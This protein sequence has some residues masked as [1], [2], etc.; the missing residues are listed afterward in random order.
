MER[1]VQ[2]S[3]QSLMAHLPIAAFVARAPDGAIVWFNA[4]AAELWGRQP[5]IGDPDERCCRPCAADGSFPAHGATPVAEVLKSGMPI[6]GK[7]MVIERPDGSRATVC[8][9]VDP[10]RDEEGTIVGV[11]NFFSDT[12]ERKA[13]ELQ[14]KKQ[15]GLLAASVQREADSEAASQKAEAMFL[16]TNRRK[17]EFLA[18]LAH[19]L[20]N[21]LA[22]IAN[23]SELL[24][25][26]LP[27]ESPAQGSVRVIQRQVYHLTRLVDD[28]LDVS[29]I[30]QGRIQLK[31]RPLKLA[32]VVTQAVE[33]VEPLLN[34]KRQKLSTT[35]DEQEIL[36]VNG[37][38]ARLVQCVGN[39]LTNAIKYT[40]PGGEIRLAPA[41][42]A[43]ARSSKSLIPAA[44]FLPNCCRTCSSCSCKVIAR[45]TTRQEAWVSASR[46]S[47]AWCKCT[48]GRSARAAAAWGGDPPLRFGCR[49]SPALASRRRRRRASSRHPGAC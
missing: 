6:H 23:A 17:D 9:Y 32:G 7:D 25:R 16:E 11:T 27:E 13:R 33:M 20:R 49:G 5:K 44:A 10:V 12:A 15:A 39:I 24:S 43:T 29:R 48:R 45:S 31:K 1:L 14:T 30:T 42:A 41:P 2:L 35:L 21:P 26:T 19:E 4:L 37:D 18:M 3:L 8:V 34:H 22:P 40:E 36:Y 46:W 28:L 38:S 47:S